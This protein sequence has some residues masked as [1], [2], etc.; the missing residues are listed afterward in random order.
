MKTPGLGIGHVGFVSH[1]EMGQHRLQDLALVGVGGGD[2]DAQRQSVRV[3]QDVHL[4]TGTGLTPV[5]GARTCKF[6]PFFSADVSGVEDSAR[7]V[8]E[9]LAV[10]ELE[11]LLVQ[12]SPHPGAGPDEKPAVRG[13]L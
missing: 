13:R 5:H 6:A 11:H 7:Q 12:S 3:G 9:V 10:Q 1:V 2:S 8:D 4:G